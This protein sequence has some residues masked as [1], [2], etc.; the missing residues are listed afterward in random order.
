MKNY[1]KLFIATTF[2]ISIF[3]YN[4]FANFTHKVNDNE[5]LWSI[6]NYYD[7]P[8]ENIVTLNP[9]IQNEQIIY[10]DT[11][12]I[13]PSGNIPV[14]ASSSVTSN[15]NKLLKLINTERQK[16][17]L[18][19]LETD[20][21]LSI[22]AEIKNKDMYVN[23]YFDH[24]SNIYESSTALLNSFNIE[25]KY[26]GENIAKGDYSSEQVF[27][28]WINNDDN[29]NIL[30]KNFTKIGISNVKEDINYWTLIFT[31]N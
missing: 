25:Y 4:T 16:K 24:S 20:E 19:P 28:D 26:F 18:Q 3:N 1:T 10:S 6:A 7:V 8:I 5:T 21:Q 31:G 27:V 30:N 29:E 13:I 2:F 22:L 9:N 17:G 14:F 12:L 23:S 15:E 11:E